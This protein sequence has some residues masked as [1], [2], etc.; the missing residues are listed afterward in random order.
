M[1]ANYGQ[2]DIALDP[3]WNGEYEQEAEPFDTDAIAFYQCDQLGTPQELTDYDGNV[4][5]SGQYKAWGQ[6]NVAI[7]E[8]A[9]K[10]GIRNP[11]RFQGQYLDDETGLHYNRHRYYDPYSGRFISKDPIGLFGGDNLFEYAPNAVQW[12]D[13]FG[14]Q[15]HGGQRV[16]GR[17]PALPEE[18]ENVRPADTDKCLDLPMTR[19]RH[20]TN[21]KG[22]LGIEATG[23]VIASDNNR[24]YL[25][26]ASKRPLSQVAAEDNYQI[27]KGRGRDYVEFDVPTSRLEWV[28]N[29]R[30]GDKELTVKGN[31]TACNLK[32]FRRN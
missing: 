31:V 27:G 1:A 21:R 29:P 8:V 6:A 25:E 7:S 10:A 26:P 17:K 28:S 16:S 4:A 18:R 19:V 9:Y 20:Y 15:R 11:I 14:L 2:Y 13:P 32:V 12:I 23:H 24:I 22:S 3:L 30:Y 5:W